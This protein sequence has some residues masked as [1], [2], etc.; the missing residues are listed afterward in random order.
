MAKAKPYY[1]MI[2]L[3]PG[4]KWSPEF[5]DYDQAAV[6]AEMDDNIQ[7]L[8]RGDWPKG[9]KFKIIKTLATQN[10]INN[11]IAVENL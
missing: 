9:T 11:R 3:V 10:S 8:R 5:S 2:V 7:A 4:Q 6:K 1:T